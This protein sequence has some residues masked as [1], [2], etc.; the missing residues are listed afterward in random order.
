M[1][2]KHK[3]MTLTYESIEQFQNSLCAHGRSEKTAKAYGTDLKTFLKEIDQGEISMEEF[4][5][6]AQNWLT[7]NRRIIAPKTTSRRLTSLRVFAKWAGHS[8][9][10]SDYSTPTVARGQSH[11]LPEGMDGVRRLIEVARNEKQKALIALCGLCGLRVAEA[12]AIKPEHFKLEQM[13]LIVR[14]K[15]DKTR[16]VPVSPEAWGVLAMSV[17]AAM[18]DGGREVVDIKDRFARRV[19]TDLGVK[20]G[21]RRHISSHDLRAT[22]ATAVYDKTQDAML[23]RELLGHSSV[24]TTQLYIGVE[25][26]KLREAVQL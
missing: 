3:V 5:M 8:D 7:A 21:L 26:T 24:V 4:E 22:F 1:K 20:A 18:C 14:G 10:L 12:L 6:T 17:T 19:I 11:P 25:M 2:Q 15:G 23:V 9:V 16:V 13:M